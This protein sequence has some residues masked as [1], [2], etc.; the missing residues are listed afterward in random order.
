MSKG[1]RWECGK[2][3]TL[4]DS[5]WALL[6]LFVILVALV[7]PVQV[8][9]YISGPNPDCFEWEG[10]GGKLPQRGC[11]Y[12][13][14]AFGMVYYGDDEGLNFLRLAFPGPKGVLGPYGKFES[15]LPTLMLEFDGELGHGFYITNNKLLGQFVFSC[16][17]LGW[18][19][20]FGW[21][22]TEPWYTGPCMELP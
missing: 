4:R 6:L 3:M 12:N 17:H 19:T 8:K 2:K 18:T 13:A 21:F 10:I 9:E 16:T 1:K 20:D 22:T 5:W 15:T 14:T 7:S 11:R